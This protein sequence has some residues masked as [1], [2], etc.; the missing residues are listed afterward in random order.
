MLPKLEKFTGTEYEGGIDMSRCASET[1]S[2]KN[3]FSYFGPEGVIIIVGLSYVG[4]QVT[5]L[6]TRFPG[7]LRPSATR[8]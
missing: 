8:L 1:P 3:I 7:V 2:A 6:Y 4:F 5:T